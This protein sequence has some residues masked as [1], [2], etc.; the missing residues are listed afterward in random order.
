LQAHACRT[1]C[2]H[3]RDARST[4]RREAVRLDRRRR[5]LSSHRRAQSTSQRAEIEGF[6]S[7]V[8][9]PLVSDE[10]ILAVVP[11][12]RVIP[13]SGAFAIGARRHREKTWKSVA[14]FHH[15]PWAAVEKNHRFRLHIA[16]QDVELLSPPK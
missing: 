12:M 5:A 15:A 2:R 11:V 9:C 10:S 1:P 7:S 4:D 16:G 3:S 6:G 14:L 13:A 8:Y